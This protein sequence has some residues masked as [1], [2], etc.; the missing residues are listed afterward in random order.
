MRGS[1]LT[2]GYFL[3]RSSEVASASIL[4]SIG[5]GA[6]RPLLYFDEFKW[7]REVGAI[8]RVLRATEIEPT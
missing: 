3:A 6:L 8:G 2:W 7:S 5:A 4:I 1:R